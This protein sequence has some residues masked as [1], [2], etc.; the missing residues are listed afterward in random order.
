[1]EKNGLLLI[2]P[3]TIYQPLDVVW[4]LCLYLQP[5]RWTNT[6]LCIKAKP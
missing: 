3:S 6:L 4:F 2:P 1:M 5:N